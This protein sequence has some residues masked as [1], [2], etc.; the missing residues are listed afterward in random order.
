VGQNRSEKVANAIRECL[1]ELLL[2]Q[3]H[4]ARLSQV[5]ITDTRVS[6][7]LRNANVYYTL[8]GERAGE[9]SVREEVE[10]GFH[11]ATP[12]LRRQLG[13]EVRMKFVPELVFHFD[14]A[15]ERA[16][17]LEQ[18]LANLHPPEEP[19]QGEEE[20]PTDDKA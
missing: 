12:F 4:D 3:V 19:A 15:E 17:R 18:I 1:S 7:D 5:V 8:M 11:A 13:K 20:E 2:T 6:G 14:E 16:R 10:R 9:Q